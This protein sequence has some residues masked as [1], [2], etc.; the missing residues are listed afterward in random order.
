MRVFSSLKG[1]VDAGLGKWSAAV[2]LVLPCT[3]LPAYAKI[4]VPRKCSMSNVPVR[5]EQLRLPAPSVYPH[6]VPKSCFESMRCLH[7]TAHAVR[8]GTEEAF[9]RLV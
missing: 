6:W 7:F 3:W 9:E 1:Q 4:A 5:T 8:R 2:Q